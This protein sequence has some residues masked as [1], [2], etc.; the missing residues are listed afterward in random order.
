MKIDTGE[1]ADRVNGIVSNAHY[2]EDRSEV[3]MMKYKEAVKDEFR[4]FAEQLLDEAAERA[5]ILI[6]EK[7]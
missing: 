7:K 5:N 3:N 1:Y 6:V 4:K 2:D